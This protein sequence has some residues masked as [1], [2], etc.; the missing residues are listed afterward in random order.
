LRVW[1]D[2]LTPKQGRLAACLHRSLRRA[3]YETL[4]TCREHECTARRGTALRGRAGGRGEVRRRDEAREAAGRR[5]A[6]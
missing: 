6:G 5:G 4:V 3:G 1:L 2:A